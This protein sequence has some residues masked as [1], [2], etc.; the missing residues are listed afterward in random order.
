MPAQD[1]AQLRARVRD[2][3]Q[4]LEGLSV[5]QVLQQMADMAQRQQRAMHS[6]Q[7]A[8]FQLLSIEQAKGQEFDHVALPFLE[9]GRFPAP[10]PQ[11]SAFLE[12]NRL[13]VAMTRARHKLWLLQKA[14]SAPAAQ[15]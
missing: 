5:P 10:A 8:D 14:P 7:G 4:A 3:I 15:A 2:F 9:P 12:R 1:R 11:D 6:P 13:Y